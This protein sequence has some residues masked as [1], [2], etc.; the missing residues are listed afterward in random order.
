MKFLVS[1]F[2]IVF[3]SFVIFCD[4]L[5]KSVS[6]SEKRFFLCVIAFLGDLCN[7]IKNGSA[8]GIGYVSRY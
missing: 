8:G 5:S 6:P 4:L 7:T 2:F 1:D 3:P